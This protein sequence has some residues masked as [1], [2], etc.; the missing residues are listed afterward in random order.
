MCE[1]GLRG[2]YDSLQ[3]VGVDGRHRHR[4]LDSHTTA[5][6][7][8]L[9]TFDSPSVS[10][11]GT[12]VVFDDRRSSI[13]EVNIDGSNLTE[14]INLTNAG[15]EPLSPMFAP[16]GKTILITEAGGRGHNGLFIMNADGS[17]MRQVPHTINGAFGSFSPSG[18][19]IVFDRRGAIYRITTSG[20]HLQRLTTAP[21]GGED[22]VPRFSPDG[23]KIVF[24]RIVNPTP[25]PA[26]Y[27]M[28]ADGSRPH[29]VA[30]GGADPSWAALP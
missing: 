14:L 5:P 29:L 11:N 8:G 30:P 18:R 9:G 3:I 21:D 27:V 16:D 1:A 23:R 13:W 28:N 12:Q 6:D 26:L 10:P 25:G 4:F 17:H 2:G 22:L 7:E 20:S 15:T 24:E 19:S